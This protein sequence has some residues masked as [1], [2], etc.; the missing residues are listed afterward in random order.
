MPEALLRSNGSDVFFAFREH[1]LML[2]SAGVMM[3]R[4][5]RGVFGNMQVLHLR[6]VR[7]VGIEGVILLVELQALGV[8]FDGR[9]EMFG[10][11]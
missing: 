2:P 6:V 1:K 5:R 3:E 8:G 9:L 7:Q 11:G 10:I 4:G